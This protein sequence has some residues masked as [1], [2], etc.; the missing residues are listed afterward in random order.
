M[1][2]KFDLDIDDAL[3][4]AVVKYRGG[5]KDIPVGHIKKQVGQ[6]LDMDPKKTLKLLAKYKLL[7]IIPLSKMMNLEIVK[8]RMVQHLLDD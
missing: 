8:N 5:I 7:P 2:I 6:M 1:I 4:K 3:G